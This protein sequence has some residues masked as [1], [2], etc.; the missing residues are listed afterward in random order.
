KVANNQNLSETEL[1][2][3]NDTFQEHVATS[4]QS[5]K[6]GKTYCF[7]C[8][9]HTIQL[10][11]YD[12]LKNITNKEILNKARK[13]VKKLRTPTIANMLIKSGLKK[14]VLDCDTRWNSIYNMLQRLCELKAFCRMK[15][16]DIPSLELSNN[17]WNLIESLVLTL[18]PVKIGSVQLQRA[19][20]TIGDFYGCWWKIRNGLIKANTELAKSITESMLKRQQILLD[21]DLFVAAIFLDPRFQPLLTPQMKIKAINHLCK[22]WTLIQTLKKRSGYSENDIPIDETEKSVLN[23]SVDPANND[24]DDDDDFENFLKE[25]TTVISNQPVNIKS[26]FQSF[27][28]TQRIS[29]NSD[30]R[31][32]W[33]S[34]KN[35]HPEL[36]ELAQVTLAIPATQVSVERTFSS[37]KF[38][39]SDLRGNLTPSLLESIIFIIF[40]VF[41]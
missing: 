6:H 32:Y 11:V 17:D 39:L 29:Y 40:R 18:A 22:L 28:G 38:I 36:H 10:C 13:V 41:V 8:S 9:A 7:R 3:E 21:N 12:G 25:S 24:D 33:A 30:I 15:A 4:L 19:D 27:D 2:I 20:I 14:A 1:E 35:E 5:N 37:L 16:A 26:I 34:K 23:M 31:E